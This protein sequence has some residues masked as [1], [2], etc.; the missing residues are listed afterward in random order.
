[1][2]PLLILALLGIAIY[3]SYSIGVKP[4]QEVYTKP[5][6]Q[7]INKGSGETQEADRRVERLDKFFKE[8]GSPLYGRGGEIVDTA[9]YNN[10]SPYLLSA[11][12][13]IESGAGRDSYCNNIMGFGAYCYNDIMD[14]IRAVSEALA[15]EGRDGKY[16]VRCTEHDKENERGGV[17]I[18]RETC[19]LRIYNP[20]GGEDYIERVLNQKAYISN[21]Q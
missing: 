12:S 14:S 6:L 10:I 16:Y 5:E 18:E 21:L 19:L 20:S 15:G 8:Y 11:I 4:K 3:E 7:S 13:V 1:M 2:K 9:D 17:Q